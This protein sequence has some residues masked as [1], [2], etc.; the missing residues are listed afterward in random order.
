[1]GRVLELTQ[2]ELQRQIHINEA[3]RKQIESLRAMYKTA[4]AQMESALR[5]RDE[6]EALVKQLKDA[7]HRIANRYDDGVGESYGSGGEAAKI[8]REALTIARR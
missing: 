6:A 3:L 7:L 8:A 5:E 2:D 1:M 4:D